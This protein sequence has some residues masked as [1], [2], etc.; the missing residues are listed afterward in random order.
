[1]CGIIGVVRR[2][3]TRLPPPLGPLTAEIVAAVEWVTSWSYGVDHLAEAAAAVEAV[4]LALRGVPGVRALLGDRAGALAIEHHTAQLTEVLGAR[5]AELD[6]GA[7]E[8]DVTELEAINA[9]LL[10]TSPSPRDRS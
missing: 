10:Y 6:A 8:I 9:C 3:S 5:E 4:D 1:M 2:R 7:L